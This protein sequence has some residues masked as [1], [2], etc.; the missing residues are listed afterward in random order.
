[1]MKR[2][3]CLLLLLLLLLGLS[4]CG[5]EPQ[6]GEPATD[7]EALLFQFEDLMTEG[8]SLQEIADALAANERI[9]FL[10]MVMEVQEGYLAGFTT[11]I[12][13]FQSGYTFGPAIGSIPFVG[14]VFRLAEGADVAAFE[15]VLTDA[16]DLRWNICVAADEAL[17]SSVDNTVFFVMC[18]KDLNAEA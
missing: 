9:P 4:A 14:Y 7:G 1:M 13:G 3:A 2:F 18:K 15:K 6:R 12:H 10:P 17:C 8:K 16:A 5:S 11:E